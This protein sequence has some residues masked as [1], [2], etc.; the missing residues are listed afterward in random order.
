MK[1]R[2][3]NLEHFRSYKELNLKIKDTKIVLLTGINGIGKTNLLEAISFLSPG[4]GFK[5]SKLDEVINTKSNKNSSSIFFV[6]E[7][8]NNKNEIGISLSN[9]IINNKSLNRKT[10]F[11]NGKKIKRQS[12]L[13]NLISLVWLTPEMDIFF[14][15]NSL[16]RRK[17]VDRCI[18]NLNPNYLNYLKIY[19]KNLKERAKILKD[20]VE[21]D[22][23][24]VYGKN[25]EKDLWLKKV[26]ERIVA[27]GIKIYLERIKFVNDFNSLSN[28]FENFPKIEIFLKGDIEQ[29]L[30]NE[31]LEKVNKFYIEKL[32]ESRKLD[33]IKGSISYGP[34]KSDL[35]V[36][37]LK[38]KLLA[39]KCSTGEQKIILISLIIQFCKLMNKNN[40]SPILLLDE[41]VAHLDEKIKLHLLN[42][43]KAL[44]NQIWMSGADINLFPKLNNDKEVLNLKIEDLIKQ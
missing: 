5:N 12:D 8:G 6:I 27:E 20:S 37:F 29:I 2:S 36:L 21:E 40:K 9:E 33:S 34:N 44:G 39:E 14:R 32:F 24:Y 31:K 41:I 1:L 43:L 7:N 13:P 11:I 17:F 26:E 30:K 16:F 15:T 18:F 23:Y 4:K 28:S 42:E 22:F 19:E 25:K 10:I 3:V 35:K 38:K